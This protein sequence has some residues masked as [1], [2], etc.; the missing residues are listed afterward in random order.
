MPWQKQFDVDEALER[1]MKLFWSRGYEATSMQDLVEHTGVN[2][3]SLYATYGDKRKLF[4]KALRMYD[5]GM[6]RQ[7]LRELEQHP[8]PRTSIRALL[9]AFA[10]HPPGRKPS[11]GCFLNNT[12][13][14]LAARDREAGRIVAGAQREIEAFF[15]RAITRGQQQGEVGTRVDAAGAARGLLATLCG[16]AVLGRSRPEPALLDGIVEDALRR[17]D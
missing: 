9:S 11:P 10:A 15:F 8:S 6:R 3:A 13:L 7:R 1:A 12:A 17:L 16:L 14:E 4:L 2:R 5:D